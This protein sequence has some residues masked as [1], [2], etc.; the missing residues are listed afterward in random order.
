VHE[1]LLYGNQPQTEV[2]IY[3]QE[4]WQKGIQASANT[5]FLL[6]KTTTS[7]SS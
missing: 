7:V 5:F 6:T 1:A 3:W 2:V 4:A